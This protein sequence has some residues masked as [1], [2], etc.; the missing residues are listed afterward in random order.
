MHKL[1]FV[2]L[3]AIVPTLCLQNL[4]AP[5]AAQP[6]R[7]TGFPICVPDGPRPCVCRNDDLPCWILNPPPNPGPIPPINNKF[8]EFEPA[9]ALQLQIQSLRL[10]LEATKLQVIETNST[11]ITERRYNAVSEIWPEAPP[12]FSFC[13]ASATGKIENCPAAPTGQ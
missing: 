12:D 2:L 6:S 10:E 8:I 11:S 9:A 5:A 3:A 13:F 4:A 1:R 7:Q